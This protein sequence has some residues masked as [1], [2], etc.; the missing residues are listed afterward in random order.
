MPRARV[1]RVRMLSSH[2]T[3]F[4]VD[5]KQSIWFVGDVMFWEEWKL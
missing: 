5:R 2:V 1:T 4:I 3:T